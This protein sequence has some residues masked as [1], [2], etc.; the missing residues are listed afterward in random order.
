VLSGHSAGDG[1]F[2]DGFSQ[3]LT[4]DTVGALAQMFPEGAARIR[5]VA[6]AACYNGHEPQIAQFRAMF[7]NLQSAW[8]YGDSAPLAESP[9]SRRDLEE[10]ERD[11]R[12][13]PGRVDP[14]RRG[15]VTWNVVD[16]MSLQPRPLAAVEDEV[17]R[18]EAAAR[19]YD[20]APP[21]SPP[22]DARLDRYY[23]SLVELEYHPD[24]SAERRAAVHDRRMEVLRLRH[25]EIFQ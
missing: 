23:T 17:A 19:P 14:P 25:P 13:G 22:H 15:M 1:V 2:G 10:W 7:P 4:W 5:H 12:G 9:A 18:R 21:S 11:S 24:L 16:G 8:M 6:I 3:A 20:A